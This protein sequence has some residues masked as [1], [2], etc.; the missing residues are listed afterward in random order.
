LGFLADFYVLAGAGATTSN[1][2]CDAAQRFL[3]NPQ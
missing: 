2:A 3:E 1:P